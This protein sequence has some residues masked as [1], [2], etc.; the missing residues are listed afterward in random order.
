M[1]LNLKKMDFV[2]TDSM[3]DIMYVRSND[4]DCI[5]SITRLYI[6]Q[7]CVYY[8]VAKWSVPQ[9]SIMIIYNSTWS[10]SIQWIRDILSGDNLP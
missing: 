1:M 6:K 10:I 2:T 9:L 4:I 8:N 5:S 7:V 3:W